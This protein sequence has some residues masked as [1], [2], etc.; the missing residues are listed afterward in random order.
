MRENTKDL[1]Q[2][3]VKDYN[4]MNLNEQEAEKQNSQLESAYMQL[5]VFR[6]MIIFF[7]CVLTVPFFMDTFYYSRHEMLDE[8][9]NMLV[10]TF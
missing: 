4:G 1:L 3:R 2:D 7:L 8:N 10:L 6:T 5:I 9:F